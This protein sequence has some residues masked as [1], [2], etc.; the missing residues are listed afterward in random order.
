MWYLSA[1]QNSHRVLRDGD[2]QPW[3][4]CQ[5]VFKIRENSLQN[6]TLAQTGI[7]FKEIPG[8]AFQEL[9]GRAGSEHWCLFLRHSSQVLLAGL[10]LG[11]SDRMPTATADMEPARICFSEASPNLFP[12]ELSSRPTSWLIE[13]KSRTRM[14]VKVSLSQPQT[15][16]N[17][18][19]A[20][21]VHWIR[22][23]S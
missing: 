3:Y 11:F 4:F 16:P 10:M 20:I 19:D 15:T 13:L 1:S 6:K 12:H 8:L 7:G 14:S 22:K 21:P 23:E 5:Q 2:S 17:L 18:W 9:R